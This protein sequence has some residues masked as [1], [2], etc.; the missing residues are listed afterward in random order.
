[1]KIKT[2]ILLRVYIAYAV[3][4]IFAFAII[5]R[6]WQL[7]FVQGE[8]WSKMADSLSTKFVNVEAVRGSIYSEDGSLIA[9]SMPEYEV[10]MDV[11]AD[12]ITDEIFKEKIDSLSSRL[13]NLFLDKSKDEYIRALK[14]ARSEGQR[15]FLVQRKVDYNQLKAL[16]TFPIFN[17]GRYKGGLI[18]LQ[19]NKRIL[20]FKLLASRTIGYYV[21]KQKPVGL[22]GAYNEYIA[23]KTGKRLMQRI[24][25]GVWMPVN[26]DVEIAPVDGSDIISTLNVN[27]QD[28]AQNALQKQLIAQNASSGTVILMEVATGE[29]RAIANLQRVAPEQYEEKYNVAVGSATEPGS[30]FKLASFLVALEDNKFSLDD[31]IDVSKGYCVYRNRIMKDSHLIKDKRVTMKNVFEQSSNVGTSLA[32][33]R[34]YKNHPEKFVEGL[35]RLGLGRKM[36]IQIPGEAR[37]MFKHPGDKGWSGTTLPWLS[38][39]YEQTITPLQT[40]TLYNAVANN[41]TMVAPKFVKEI[42]YLGKTIEKFDTKVLVERIASES[43]IQKAHEL[44]EAVVQNGSGKALN[45]SVFPIAGKTGTA[46]I[47]D[48][49]KGYKVKRYQASFCGYFPANNPKYSMIV[50][51]NEPT[52]QLYYG[53]AVA[54]PVFKEVADKVYATQLEIHPGVEKQYVL[55][56]KEVPLAKVGYRTETEYIYNKLKVSYSENTKGNWVQTAQHDNSVEMNERNVADKAVPN[57]VGMGLKDAIYILEN[58]GLRTVARGCGKV[59][60]QSMTAGSPIV[61]GRTIGLEL[62]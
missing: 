54:A 44:L 55:N 36:G 24:A 11:N 45:T 58:A 9:T 16:K 31:T 1:M 21:D 32:I 59:V 51:I 15:Y 49:T 25:G 62:R 40:L 27:I 8:K 57:V 50:V 33:T 12:P 4:F 18:V 17:M 48:G 6:I 7:Q 41:G 20:P 14:M 46:Q 10:R 2:D 53:G 61:K 38:I 60:G 52:N 43:T 37:P 56:D 5:F 39:G 42:K 28:V 13:S 47:A 30:T 29:I 34:A 23:G 35:E 26:D 22:E 19:K 3:L